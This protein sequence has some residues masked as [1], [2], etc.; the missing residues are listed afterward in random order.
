MLKLF[1]ELKRRKVYTVATYYMVSSWLILQVSDVLFPAFGLPD[2]AMRPI[3]LLL[4]FGLPITVILAWAVD[5]TPEGISLTSEATP[6]TRTKLRTRDYITIALLAILMV[7]AAVQQYLIFTRPSTDSS[8]LVQT[9]SPVNSNG[10]M[11]IAVLPLANLSPNP[12]NSYFAAG[13]HEEILNQL[14][15]IDAME[16]TSRTA[17]LR[18]S[19]TKRPLSEIA[20]ELGVGT[21]M[22]GS[23]RFADN[24]VRIKTELVRADDVYL[25]AES[26]EFQLDDI[27][28]IQTDVALKVADAMHTSI[29]PSEIENI[30]RPPTDSTEAYA[31]YLKYR[32]QLHLE[33]AGANLEEDG[34]IEAGI[35]RLEEAVSIDP[36]FA[37]GYAELG[38]V[39]WMKGSISPAEQ[40]ALYDQALAYANKAISIDPNLTTAYETLARVSFDRLLWSDWETNAR[41]SVELN[42]LDGRAAFNF[43]MTLTNVGQYSEAYQWYDVAISKNPSIPFFREA[44]I[45][46]HI[47]GGDYETALAQT[48]Q[49]LAVGGD[50]NAYLTL[51]AYTLHKLGRERESQEALAAISEEPMLVVMW[52]TPGYQDYLR[53]K[54]G[55]KDAVMA[56]LAELEIGVARELRIQ[57][58]AAGSADNNALFDSFNR[59]IE[60]G[61]IIYLTD[62]VT[63]DVKADPR[64]QLVTDYMDYPRG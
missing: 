46:A 49:F 48:E 28:A 20:R 4:F 12:E 6:E 44:A 15:K 47:W 63:E 50:K 39:S 9:T 41:K 26:Y 43:A 62:V 8:A 36:E 51:R 34:W 11:S 40:E 16:V 3:V 31:L 27:F 17:V 54:N 53:C 25:W 19:D 35:R 23:V 1:E 2:T 22:T 21:I 58:C 52:V 30:Q 56:E 55:Q 61:Q 13:I 60:R 10:D 57:H 5:V 64:W 24:K 42:D 29:L 33:G 32:Y 18:Y 45:A 14:V 59:T 37:P 38:F 7:V